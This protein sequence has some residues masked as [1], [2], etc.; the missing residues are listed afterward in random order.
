MT[1]PAAPQRLRRVYSGPLAEV[2]VVLPTGRHI[3][4]H[5]GGEVEVLPREA[6]ALDALPGWDAPAPAAPDSKEN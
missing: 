6:E 3:T 1:K 2:L 5:R 4:V